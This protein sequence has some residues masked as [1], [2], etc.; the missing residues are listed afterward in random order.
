MIQKL[1]EEYK[2]AERHDYIHWGYEEYKGE[3]YD[4][5]NNLLFFPNKIK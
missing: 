1:V 3:D 4:W 5:F 2:A